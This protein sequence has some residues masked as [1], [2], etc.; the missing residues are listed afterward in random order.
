MKGLFIYAQDFVLQEMEIT[1][2]YINQ[3]IGYICILKTPC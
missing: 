1:N 2:M 3:V